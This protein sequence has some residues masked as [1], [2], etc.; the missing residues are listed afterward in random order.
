M[1]DAENGERRNFER[2]RSYRQ[3]QT[4][5]NN[6][7]DIIVELDKAGKF[8]YI[9]PQIKKLLG[10]NPEELLKTRSYK[11][12]HPNDIDKIFKD[13]RRMLEKRGSRENKLAEKS[14]IIEAKIRDV[15]D[16]YV[17]V[18]FRGS[19]INT[20]ENYKILGII[21]D[22]TG[23]KA[24][25][26]DLIESERR[27][28]HLFHSA[29]IMI[30]LI[31]SEG[32]IIDAN[33]PFI[34][35]FTGKEKRLVGQNFND[36]VI[37]TPR[38]S[39]FIKRR[40][41]E[42]LLRGSIE[43]IE[44][45]VKDINEEEKWISLKAALMQIKSEFFTHIIITD[46]SEYK[47]NELKLKHSERKFRTL[48]QNSPNGVMLLNYEGIVQDCN[49]TS[50]NIIGLGSEE[51]LNESFFDVYRLHDNETFKDMIPSKKLKIGENIYP[52]ELHFKNW[53]DRRLWVEFLY[54]IVS[55]G[56]DVLIQVVSSDITVNKNAEDLIKNEMKK[57]KEIDRLKN[58]FVYRASHELKTPLNSINAASAILQRYYSDILNKKVL[59]LID[60]INRGGRR[61][62]ILVKDL[63]DVSK[64]ESKRV[65]LNKKRIDLIK[66]VKNSIEIAKNLAEQRE[67]LIQEDLND[68]ISIY[69]DPDKIEQV[70]L[71][72]LSNAIKNTPPGG[73]ISVG[74]KDSENLV[75]IIIEDDG[76]GFTEHEK[77]RAFKKF[78]KIE[79][80]GKGM[81]LDTEGS[82]LGL[83]ISKEI[84]D[85]H[86][87]RIILESKGRNKGSKFTIR[88][89]K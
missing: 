81:D 17:P 86:Q 26:S 57:L 69:I 49:A 82:G 50:Q 55:I 53:K 5:I 76:I 11:L 89:P 61:L 68:N 15:N 87:G 24:I 38:N 19:I 10:Y 85:L 2:K 14:F 67:H 47:K 79:R 13:V 27:Y 39:D 58:E 9:S 3:F 78:G 25:E 44:L 59:K 23:Q 45:E 74:V 41:E 54:S 4:M 84:V 66:I 43:P 36:L 88:L 30:S 18:S 8:T 37:L 22:I 12:L 71:N 48:V 28:R 35:F 20:K 33:N 56:D 52:I 51:I 70:F 16:N 73:T 42:S 29:P 77:K 31:D 6:I 80:H 21:R 34:Q 65:T 32:N 64:I 60:I 1:N 46:I 72:I 63:I 40:F 62:K 83:Y 7:P 75:E